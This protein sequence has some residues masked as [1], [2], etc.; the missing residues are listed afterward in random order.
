MRTGSVYV[1]VNPTSAGGR[2]R[3]AGRRVL[4]ALAG[5][6]PL[7]ARFTESPGHAS[8]LAAEAVAGGASRI[9]VVGGDGTVHEVA[10]G[11]LGSGSG[12]DALPPVAVHPV[13]TGNDFFRMTRGGRRLGDALALLRNGV[14]ERFDVGRVRWEGGEQTFVNLLGLGVDVDVLRRR[15]KYARL[16]GLAQ[17]LAAF[18][19]AVV[20]FRP[21][22]VRIDAKGSASGNGGNAAQSGVATI[23]GPTTLATITVG[24]SIGGGFMI[25]PDARASDGQLDL[26]HVAA[27]NWRQA[28]ALAPRAIRGTHG[29]SKRVTLG[30]LEEAVVRA[31]DGDPIHFEL[32][33]E[34]VPTPARELRIRVMPGALPV[35]V[36]ARA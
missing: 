24:P 15:S 7:L 31:A 14:V 4:E 33:G 11:L 3:K 1:V 32:D 9:L 27:L 21:P 16:P 25:S 10:A 34:L 18:L 19:D 12:R 22:N 17:Y 6:F 26:C 20:R 35:L 36:P 2:G 23:S 30:R 5:S 28:V 29:A 13:G 8:R